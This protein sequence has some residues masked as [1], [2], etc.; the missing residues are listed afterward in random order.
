[1]TDAER[2]AV[3]RRA[4]EAIGNRDVDA[5]LEMAHPEQWHF[6]V[7]GGAVTETG[8]PGGHDGV[9]R[10][11][12]DVT[13]LSGFGRA[14]RDIVFHEGRVAVL[15][16]TS[17]RGEFGHEISM[18]GLTYWE[19]DDDGRVRSILRITDPARVTQLL[20]EIPFRR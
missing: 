3:V 19:V 15:S 4:Y 16:T 13:N 8:Q 6:D 18:L 2:I 1:M 5:M 10:W 14:P 7:E 17:A 11:F 12:A 20:S 9:R